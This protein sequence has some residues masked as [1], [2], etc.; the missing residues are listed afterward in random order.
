M[1]GNH[2][3]YAATEGMRDCRDACIV[4]LC[5]GKGDKC[6]CSNSR[7]ISLSSGVIKL[8]GRVP[9][10][11]VRDR[12]ECAIVQEQCGYRQSRGCMDH[13]FALKQVCEKYLAYGKHL[14]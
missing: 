6:D 11:R 10:K 1:R 2:L 3:A 4:P 7:G 8:Y 13:A 5:E 14:F 9:I 12:T